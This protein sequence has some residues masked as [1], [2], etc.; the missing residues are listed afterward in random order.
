[1]TAAGRIAGAGLWLLATAAAVVHAQ[2]VPAQRGYHLFRP[3]PDSL[4][5]PL[6]TDRPDVTESPYSV[7]AG[8]AQVEVDLANVA[9]KGGRVSDASMAS[10]TAKLGLLRMLD[11]QFVVGA[12]QYTDQASEAWSSV[13]TL[14]ARVK[15]NLVG[16]D[17]GAVALAVMPT[18]TVPLDAGA[19]GRAASLIVPAAFALS[20]RIGLGVMAVVEGIWPEDG[21]AT[22]VTTLTS[23]LS[24][25][26]TDRLGSYVEG[27]G[28]HV[29]GIGWVGS[30][31][32]GVTLQVS[33]QVQLDGG[34]MVPIG[35]AENRDGL[36]TFLGFAVRF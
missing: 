17:G 36:G 15:W 4:L 9:W 2:P 19:D 27:V 1:V 29:E 14:T 25:G 35:P 22:L 13:S 31:N 3:V 30:A 33:A 23:S 24:R 20:D 16:N 21:P 5:R 18:L 7:D 28:R 8:R 32:A 6:R 26:W 10:V 34:V 11:L 12:F